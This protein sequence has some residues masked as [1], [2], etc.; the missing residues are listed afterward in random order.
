MTA[1]L[2]KEEAHKLVDR[3]PENATWDDLM[4]EIYVREAIEQ[5]M[6]DSMAGRTKEV[7]DIRLKYGLPK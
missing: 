3:M 4:Y 7:K 2:E 6:A 1:S 5:G